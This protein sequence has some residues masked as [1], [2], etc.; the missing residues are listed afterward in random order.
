MKLLLRFLVLLSLFSTT[1]SA[2]EKEL[3]RS[4]VIPNAAAID[5]SLVPEGMRDG[6]RR[7]FAAAQTPVTETNQCGALAMPGHDQ[8]YQSHINATSPA[9]STKT[10]SVARYGNTV[11]KVNKRRPVDDIPLMGN[12][13]GGR[14]PIGGVAI[15]DPG[16]PRW[17]KLLEGLNKSVDSNIGM[18]LLA[19]APDQAVHTVARNEM[20]RNRGNKYVTA[21]ESWL[22]PLAGVDPETAPLNDEHFAVLSELINGRSLAQSTLKGELRQEVKDA[23]TDV[24]METEFADMHRGNYVVH[25]NAGDSNQRVTL[26]DNEQIL[27]VNGS[28]PVRLFVDLVFGNRARL[29][30]L[31]KLG[32]S[33]GFTP[34]MISEI[35]KESL[36]ETLPRVS[37]V[38]TLV[39]LQTRHV[40]KMQR[41]HWR[42]VGM[43]EKLDKIYAEKGFD[44]VKQSLEEVVGDKRPEVLE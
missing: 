19:N 15:Q 29:E 37:V 41:Q 6:A 30:G 44:A 10:S 23:M 9:T 16:I 24:I 7:A 2:S 43:I 11:L 17:V 39:F 28:A 32:I 18:G 34:K 42:F 35:K 22:I 36:R 13:R 8:L 12:Y 25:G 14:V 31:Y 21:P 40:V 26:I 1:V 27:L 3:L 38:L 33:D 20:L 5:T 4:R